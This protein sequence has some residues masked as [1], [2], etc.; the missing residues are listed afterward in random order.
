MSNR[1]A[2]TSYGVISSLGNNFDEIEKS[3]LNDSTNFQK[4]SFDSEVTICP[5]DGFNIRNIIGR[6][7]N[8]KYLSRGSQFALGASWNA[9][10]D[11]GLNEK[12]LSEC[13]LF[14]GSGPNLD[15]ANEFP[16]ILDGNLDSSS[17]QA[18]WILK[19]LPNT[20]ASAISNLLGLHGENFSIGTACAASLQ[21]VGEAYRKVKDGYLNTALVAGGDSRISTGGILGYKKAQALYL[22][23][24]EPKKDYS[25]FGQNRKGFIP[26]EGGAAIV[27]ENLDQALD[28]GAN[29]LGEI[30]GYGASIDGHNMTAP[31]PRG[32][33]AIKAVNN[34]LSESFISGSS[35]DL[36][37]AHGTGTMLNDEIEAEL[38]KNVCGSSASVTAYKSWIGHLS[39][40]CGIMELVLSMFSMNKSFI[41]EIRNLKNPCDENISFIESQTQKEV[42]NVLLQNF[43]FG[44]Q[45][46]ALVLR[47]WKK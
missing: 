10:K 20:A 12:M 22:N 7:K 2:I 45:N 1:V 11:S 44:G 3:F 31:H 39:S 28:R 16:N 9:V 4:C 8:S 42:N 5:I 18:L 40:S 41:P 15:I 43:G 34:A 17:L 35:I 46:S 32:T 24:N 29:I 6:N 26:G 36:I 14:V 47:S 33:F 25:P 38:I 13:G 37:S 19:Y 21:G 23:C 30:V 27:L